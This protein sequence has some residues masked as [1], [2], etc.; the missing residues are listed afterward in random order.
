M[1]NIN[2]E[3]AIRSRLP[4]IRAAMIRAGDFDGLRET[5]NFGSLTLRE[6]LDCLAVCHEGQPSGTP[7][8]KLTWHG[9][10]FAE[11]RDWESAIYCLDEA[12][13]QTDDAGLWSKLD[14]ILLAIAVTDFPLQ[15]KLRILAVKKPAEAEKVI[16]LIMPMETTPKELDIDDIQNACVEMRNPRLWAEFV[17]NAAWIN[18]GD[19]V[20]FLAEIG[21]FDEADA[22]LKALLEKNP[23]GLHDFLLLLED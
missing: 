19:R 3:I 9:Q 21:A 23:E 1:L 18:P 22:A 5:A 12:R 10:R 13:N 11:Q 4:E 8:E 17:R 16:R 6:T 15:G 7:F 20:E 2:L 14:G